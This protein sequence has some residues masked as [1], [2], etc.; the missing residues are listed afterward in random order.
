[1]KR[2]TLLKYFLLPLLSFAIITGC[3]ED[4]P[5]QPSPPV[6]DDSDLLVDVLS[7]ALVKGGTQTVRVSAYD[8]NANPEKFEVTSGNTDIATATKLDTTSFAVG[9]V[10]YGSTNI[11][12]TTNSG[13]TK[14][15]P[16][17]I[18]NP[19]I[20]ETDELLITYAQT[21]HAPWYCLSDQPPVAF[22][23]PVV[24][25]GFRS[26]GSLCYEGSYNPDGVHGVMVVKAKP[27]SN[28]LAAPVDYTDWWGADPRWDNCSF[29]RPIP[30]TGYRAMGVVQ[31]AGYNKPLLDAVTCVREDL[32]IMGEAGDFIAEL[33]NGL[34]YHYFWKIEPPV[35]GPH[36]NAYFSTGTFVS[37]N[38][39]SAPSIDP[40]MNVLNV[41]LPMLTEAP[42]QQYV[43]KLTGYDPP[44][45]ET[46]PVLAREMLV[47]CTML[48]DPQYSSDQM[49]RITNSPFY[50]LERQVFYKRLY[51]NHNQ[52]SV[53]QH[54][55]YTRRSGV[56]TQESNEFWSETGISISAEA[57]INISVFSA[58]V[59][60]NVSK[61]LGYS[62]MTSISELEEEEYESGIDVLPGKAVAIWQR[63]NRFV[64]KRHN[65]TSL[66][67]VKMWEFGINSFI[68]DEYPD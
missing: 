7:V 14:E 51:H 24:T 11:V 38:A 16:T 42:Y 13:K 54:N 47:P 41:Q 12:V 22:A 62:R 67:S 5:T 23:Y 64:L 44:P 26:L 46:V 43:P 15:I 25:D 61:S 63:Y 2:V 48:N 21:F 35:S 59:S 31:W 18:Y 9:G 33:I 52:T 20:L 45:G 50:R 3:G 49:W 55:S 30:P 58:G 39:Y 28:A 27:G 8:K 37:A 68:T 65:G 10:N 34:Y 56:T 19:K 40:V 17:T 32:T 60:T 36:E 1:M 66:E 6:T 53:L 29:W 4:N 57:G